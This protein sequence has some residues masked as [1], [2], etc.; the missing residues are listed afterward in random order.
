LGAERGISKQVKH[1]DRTGIPYVL[2]YGG[3][4]KEKGVVTVKDMEAGRM[5]AAALK[6][7]EEWLE[8]RPG[9][10][11][12]SRAQLAAAMKEVVSRS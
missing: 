1:A 11:E 6:S 5:K 9:Q 12:V 4:E 10:F 8:Q 2:L 7:R 3:N